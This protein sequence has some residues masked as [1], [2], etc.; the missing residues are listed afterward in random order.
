MRFS[1]SAHRL[2]LLPLE[3]LTPIKRTDYCSRTH[4]PGELCYNFSVSNDLTQMV[5]FPIRIPDCDSDSPA[6]L[7]FFLI[8]DAIICSTLAFPPLGNSVHVSVSIYFPSNPQQDALFHCKPYHYSCSDWDGLHDRLR[9][10]PWEDMFKLGASAAVSEFCE[11]VQVGI[12]VCIP[13]KKY[14]VKPNLCC[15]H[16]S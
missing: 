10:V 3:T 13:H 4:Q 11:W 2:I 16:S 9:D 12:D 7:D 14:Q 8:S 5:N 6:L 15:C 1:P